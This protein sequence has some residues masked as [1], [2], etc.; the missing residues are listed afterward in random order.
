MDSSTNASGEMRNT[1]RTVK[2]HLYLTP[3]KKINLKRIEDLNTKPDAIKFLEGNIGKKFA[4]VGLGN[5][6]FFFLD[7]ML[8]TPKTEAK[9]NK[10]NYINWKPSHKIGHIQG[11]MAIDQLKS[12][13]MAEGRINKWQTMYRMGEHFCKPYIR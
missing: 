6:F 7:M 2:L 5:D 4:D 3:L 1:F 12:F 11:G 10:W 9:I 13:C 8:K